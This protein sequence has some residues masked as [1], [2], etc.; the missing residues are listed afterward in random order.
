MT[1]EYRI[2]TATKNNKS[3]IINISKYIWSGDDY[4]PTVIDEWLTDNNA[5]IFLL[6]YDGR[7][8]HFVRLRFQ[9]DTDAWLEALRGMPEYR[10]KGF[11]LKLSEYALE[12]ALNNGANTIRSST[13]YKNTVTFKLMK[14][15]NIP[16]KYK[17]HFAWITADKLGN[18]NTEGVRQ[19][20]ENEIKELLKFL[21]N[22]QIYN[23]GYKKFI[24]NGWVYYKH[25][26]NIWLNEIK[27]GNV[28]TCI[29]SNNINSVMLMQDSNNDYKRKVIGMLDGNILD[30]EKLIRFAENY[31]K[32]R[33]ADLGFVTPANTEL[34]D[35]MLD[36]GF[37]PWEETDANI[38]V[39]EQSF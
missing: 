5:F 9:S 23:T 39:F 21:D 16:L 28:Y 1:P 26:D 3:D 24:T 2:I 18:D 38:V 6:E 35:Y 29:N 30:R 22:S 10:G 15:L 37:E 34:R 4:V 31:M 36:Y 33:N 17:F 8:T 25:R 32:K 14:K 7:F 11:G 13:Y 19:V 27:K 20:K 12:F